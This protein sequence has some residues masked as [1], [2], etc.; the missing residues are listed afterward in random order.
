MYTYLL[1]LFITTKLTSEPSIYINI[2]VLVQAD[3]VAVRTGSLSREKDTH[4]NIGAVFLLVYFID[5][6][7][8]QGILSMFCVVRYEGGEMFLIVY[9]GL[10]VIFYTYIHLFY[11]SPSQQAFS[12]AVCCRV[13]RTCSCILRTYNSHSTSVKS[14]L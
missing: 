5:S 11:I 1:F 6:K 13:V 2:L 4:I 14:T 12:S 10:L 3:F 8:D 9:R 7:T